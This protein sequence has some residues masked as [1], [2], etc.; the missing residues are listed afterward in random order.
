MQFCSREKTLPDISLIHGRLLVSAWEE[1]LEGVEDA[2]VSLTL[3]AAEA[4]LRRLV[5]SLV[6]SRNSWRET[7]GMRHSAGVGPPDPWLLNSVE[8]MNYFQERKVEE[9]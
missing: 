6:I 3:A 7:T 1:G 2:A 9:A 5:S 4:H 8:K